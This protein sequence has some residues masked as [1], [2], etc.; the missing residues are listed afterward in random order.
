MWYWYKNSHIEQ[1][2]R[3]KKG[4]KQFRYPQ[5]KEWSWTPTSEN[6]VKI[7]PMGEDLNNVRAKTVKH[8]KENKRVNLDDLEFGSGF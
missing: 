5:A 6:Y 4:T 8:L 1:Q 7:K 3:T 2:S